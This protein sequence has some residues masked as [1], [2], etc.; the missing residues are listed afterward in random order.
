MAEA[1]LRVEEEGVDRDTSGEA[2]EGGEGS[3]WKG[4][5]R[6]RSRTLARDNNNIVHGKEGVSVSWSFFAT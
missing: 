1:A 4:V 3:G 6:A 2:E 5:R